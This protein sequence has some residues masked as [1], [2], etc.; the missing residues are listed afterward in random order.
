MDIPGYPDIDDPESL[1]EI[2]IIDAMGILQGPYR[3]LD[4]TKDRAG[5]I[6]VLDLQE[7]RI[8]KT[9]PKRICDANGSMA[10]VDDGQKVAA[11]PKCAAI[12][13]VTDEEGTCSCG[14][15]AIAGTLEVAKKSKVVVKK[16]LPEAV[17]LGAIAANGEL[18]IREDVPFD[19]G[20]T[21]VTALSLRIGGRYISFNLYNGSFGKKGKD[22]PIE[23]LK[24]G[25]TGYVIKGIDKWKKKLLK[26]GYKPFV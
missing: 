17:D 10:I 15:F 16:K 12:C 11:C 25:E 22:P 23:Q 3:L 26:K 7:N 8:L 13:V 9:H 6:A 24:R 5:L 18:W 20:K 2:K 19:N 14:V 1:P 21:K 4:S